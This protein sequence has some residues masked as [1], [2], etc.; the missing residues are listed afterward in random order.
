MSLQPRPPGAGYGLGELVDE[1][2]LLRYRPDLTIN[3]TRLLD[4]LANATCANRDE[5][6]AAERLV[7]D[8]QS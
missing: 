2:R 5:R 3:Q 8:L 7:L 4:A 1:A 6:W